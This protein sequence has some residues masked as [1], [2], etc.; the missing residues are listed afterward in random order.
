MN[1][2]GSYVKDPKTGKVELKERTMSISEK[3]EADAK[4]T[5]TQKDKSAKGDKS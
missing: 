4:K 2:G 5:A 1:K 3:R